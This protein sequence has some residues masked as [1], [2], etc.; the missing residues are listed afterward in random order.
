MTAPAC[1][2]ITSEELADWRRSIGRTETRRQVLDL[3]S[4]RRYAAAVGADLDVERCQPPLAHWAYFLE[5]LDAGSLDSDGHALRDRGFLPPVRLPR[6]MF[7]STRI[8]FCEPLRLAHEAELTL[9]LLS[10]EHRVNAGGDLVFV[11]FDRSMR[12]NGVTCLIESQTLVYRAAHRASHPPVPSAVP[13]RDAEAVWVP[14]TVDLFRFSA[15]TFNSHR[16]HYDLPYARDEEGYPTLVVQGPLTAVKL[17]AFA[18]RRLEPAQ[19]IARFAMRAHAP[20][21]V[22]QPV[23]LAPGQGRDAVQA[24]RCDGTVAMTARVTTSAGTG[25]ASFGSCCAQLSD[26]VQQAG[27]DS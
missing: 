17:L 27:C 21:F 9:T 6:R 11:E 23:R 4:L 5:A 3:E 22:G 10:I 16:I 20:L 13:D 14:T 8:Q 25:W 7:A 2:P 15:A 24:I 1:D 18:Q 19:T 26:G 12:Q